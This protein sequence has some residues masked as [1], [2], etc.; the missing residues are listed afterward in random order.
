MDNLS[1]CTQLKS[2]LFSIHKK[3]HDCYLEMPYV[4]RLGKYWVGVQLKACELEKELG[5]MEYIKEQ[6][7]LYH[8]YEEKFR[9]DIALGCLMNSTRSFYEYYETYKE[10][11]DSL[12]RQNDLIEEYL[13]AKDSV[14]GGYQAPLDEVITAGYFKRLAA[15]LKELYV[16]FESYLEKHPQP[17][18]KEQ[19]A[20][21]DM[22]AG[23]YFSAEFL[24]QLHC[25]VKEDLLEEYT[26]FSWAC[27][28]NLVKVEGPVKFK[29][30]RGP[31]TA[32][33][34]QLYYLVF[35]LTEYLRSSKRLGNNA[36]LWEKSILRMMGID[37]Q[38]YRKS[39]TKCANPAEQIDKPTYADFA[40]TI[41]EF[42]KTHAD[43]SI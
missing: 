23:E 24:S 42:F 11:L 40:E 26:A 43:Y 7:I 25:A 38:V 36:S 9:K 5:S 10:E 18:Q 22:P 34:A 27:I 1:K 6:W 15:K 16:F 32:G 21:E 28:W 33:S 37:W 4:R 2:Y 17:Q 13:E 41:E 14:F 3:I 12:F 39:R 35:R 8:K 20:V 19:S 29:R 30:Q 31:K